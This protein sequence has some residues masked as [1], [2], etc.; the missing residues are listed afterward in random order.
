MIAK[1]STPTMT[2]K[3]YLLDV[4]RPDRVN[5]R[6]K[7]VDQMLTS[8]RRFEAFLGRPST[9]QDLD[10]QTF[11]DFK[12]A[13]GG[14]NLEDQ[15]RS[16]AAATVN[17]KLRDLCAIWQLAW[18]RH[19]IRKAPRK[20]RRARLPKR[21]PKAYTLA[22][23]RLILKQAQSLAGTVGLVGR[24]PHVIERRL[25]WPAL[26]HTCYS[27]A[28][29]IGALLSASPQDYD[30]RRLFL[31]AENQ[32]QGADQTVCLSA[33]AIK[34]VDAIYDP[35]RP[36]LFWWPYGRRYLWRY[37]KKRILDPAGIVSTRKGMDQFQKY[38]RT[39]LSYIAAENEDQAVKVAGHSSP[40]ITRRNYLDPDIVNPTG[41]AEFIPSLTETPPDDPEGP[42]VLSMADYVG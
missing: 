13:Y 12:A 20:I 14:G 10:E 3:R 40:A 18:D 35:R 21:Q 41:A 9:L 31:R 38:R 16:P 7:T 36:E 8:L 28:A 37:H 34:A 6:T 25:W 33:E 22:Q 19:D 32:K 29:R 24:D 15:K 23:M 17:S 42:N 27:T 39:G 11:N 2:L 5:L 4:Y 26:I 30:G 1:N